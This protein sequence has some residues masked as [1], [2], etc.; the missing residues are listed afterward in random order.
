MNQALVIFDSG[1]GGFS[2]LRVLLAK[3]LSLPFIYLADQANLPYG[4]KTSTWLETR[5][6]QVATFAKSLTPAALVLACNTAT[7]SGVSLFR[8]I[9][10]CPVVGVEPV[11]KP[12]SKYRH[13]LVLATQATLNSPRHQQLV[14][15]HNPQTLAACPPN[16]VQ[17]I[18]A[19]D[20]N[21][22]KQSLSSLMPI[23]K[24]QQVDVLGLSCTHYPLVL[25]QI[26]A[27]YPQL[28]VYDPS[29]AVINELLHQLSPHK[30]PRLQEQSP[31]REFFT[32]GEPK[33][34]QTQVQYY[35][36]QSVTATKLVI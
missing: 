27:L 35:L 21:L 34:L 18:E 31:Q 28:S 15:A 17:A 6:T 7:V 11:V 33:V 36:N 13:P 14:K 20:E 25:A 12:L 22:I 19:M 8:K 2:L 3:K 23:I 5:L 26:K 1:I 16:L 30:M 32:T 29:P 10:A 4:N 24:E 9:L